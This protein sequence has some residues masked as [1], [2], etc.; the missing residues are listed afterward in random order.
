MRLYLGGPMSGHKDFNFPAFHAYAASLRAQGHFVFSP[1]ENS[2]ERYGDRLANS[3]G[4]EKEASKNAG[5]NRRAVMA[6]DMRFICLEADGIALMP[7]WEKSSGARAEWA[8][9]NALDLKVIYLD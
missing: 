4:S 8:L 5:F 9:A 1:A 7:G 6:D 3:A 2:I